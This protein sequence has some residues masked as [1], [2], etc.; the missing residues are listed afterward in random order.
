MESLLIRPKSKEEMDLLREVFKRMNIYLE[1]IEF[2]S[3]IRKVNNFLNSLASRIFNLEIGIK[4]KKVFKNAF[5]LI[6]EI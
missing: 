1:V 2:D 4:E 5:D 3:K 6:N